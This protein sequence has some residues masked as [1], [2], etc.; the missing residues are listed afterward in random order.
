MIIAVPLLLCFAQLIP[1]VDACSNIILTSGA[2]Q[3]SSNVVAYNADSATLFGSLYH[4]AAAKHPEGS[5]RKIYDWDSGRYLGEIDEVPNTFNVVG[6]TN[7]FGLVIGETTYGGLA[8]LQAQSAA[9][10]DYGSLIWVTL[11]RAKTA[12]E[13]IKTLGGLMDTYGY[14]SEGESFSIADPNEAW[15]MELIGKGEY[16]KGAVWVARRIPSGAVCGHANQVKP[17]N[18]NPNLNLTPARHLTLHT[19]FVHCPATHPLIH[20]STHL[21]PHS[22]SGSNHDLPPQR[23]GTC[24]VRPRRHLLRS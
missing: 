21:T 5:K 11:M 10:M 2:T 22:H 18:P 9:I 12:R 1:N 19:A 13:A 14:A 16:E 8:S 17:P 20:S 15:V 3:D 7:E 23:P 6:N 24:S 4:Y